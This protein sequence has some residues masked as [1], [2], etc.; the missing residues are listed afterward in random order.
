MPTFHRIRY[1]QARED[2]TNTPVVM[3]LS[4]SLHTHIAVMA[5]VVRAEVLGFEAELESHYSAAVQTPGIRAKDNRASMDNVG[6][7]RRGHNDEGP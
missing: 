4:N 3:D 5:L 2:S 1:M 6:A 7:L